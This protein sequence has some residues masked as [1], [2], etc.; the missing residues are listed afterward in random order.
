M[1]RLSLL[2]SLI[3]V[4]FTLGCGGVKYYV[5][6]GAEISYVR[7]VA[8]LPFQNNTNNKHAA[9]RIRDLVSTEILARGTFEVVEKGCVDTAIREEAL[10]SPTSLDKNVARRLARV[11]DVQA[12]LAG[13]VDQYKD[14][15]RGS[16][17][18]PVVSLTLRLIDGQTGTILWQASGS[19]SGYSAWGR[20]LGLSPKDMTQVSMEL[21]E[22]LLSTLR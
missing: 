17:S 12:F 4:I 1:R 21:V 16:Y 10:E 18:Y 9:E 8:V 5:K 22:R 2:S 20:L 14:A 13:S 19:A 6:E 3:C 7:R 11:L 15:R